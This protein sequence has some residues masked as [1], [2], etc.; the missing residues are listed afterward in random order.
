MSDLVWE[1][2]LR[3]FVA[4]LLVALIARPVSRLIF[5]L[6]PDGKLRRFLFISW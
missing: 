4:L 1:G 2:L 5:R 6:L 3:P